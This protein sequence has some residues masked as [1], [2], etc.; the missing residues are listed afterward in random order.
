MM[1]TTML[2]VLYFDPD[3]Y[4]VDEANAIY[5]AVIK[6]MPSECAQHTVCLPHDWK[7]VQYPMEGTFTYDLRD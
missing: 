5:Q 1:N 2:N 6:Q 4:D 3:K 7:L